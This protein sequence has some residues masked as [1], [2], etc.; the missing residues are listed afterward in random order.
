MGGAVSSRLLEWLQAGPEAAR[1]TK[2]LLMRAAPLPDAA[3]M[4]ATARTTA[5]VRG[6]AEAHAGLRA[7]YD[8][9]AAPWV[10]KASGKA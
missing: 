10:R 5:E 3:L 7:F 6:G 9:A 1:R 2:A 8:K 4:E